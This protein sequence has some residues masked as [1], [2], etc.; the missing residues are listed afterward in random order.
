MVGTLS[1]PT[2]GSL[3]LLVQLHS[4]SWHWLQRANGQPQR[5]C[6]DERAQVRFLG[7]IALISPICHIC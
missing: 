7:R 2:D 6:E 4:A 1:Q 3:A 5:L